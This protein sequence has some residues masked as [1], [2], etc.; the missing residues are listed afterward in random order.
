MHTQPQVVVFDT[1]N[2]ADKYYGFCE[3]DDEL[4][5][6]NLAQHLPWKAVAAESFQQNAKARALRRAFYC[7][8]DHQNNIT[9]M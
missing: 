4:E 5:L 9:H 7:F 3:P 6:Y 1:R 2:S 8:C